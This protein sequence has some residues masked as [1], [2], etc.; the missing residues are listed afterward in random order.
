MAGP[1][2]NMANIWKKKPFK[3][4]PPSPPANLIDCSNLTIDFAA[5]KF[6]N[7]GLDPTDEFNTRIHIITASRYVNIPVDFLNR[8]FR[9]MGNILSFILDQPEKYKRKLF[10]ETDSIS[11]SSMVYQ[12]ENTLVIESKIQDGCRVL[13]NRTDL[14]LLQD[15]ESTIS[16]IIDRKSIIIKPIVIHQID[17]IA[18][19]LKTNSMLKHSTLEIMRNRVRNVNNDFISI[20][21]IGENDYIF[22]SQLKLY[23]TD[24]IVQK[25]MEKLEKDEGYNGQCSLVYSPPSFNS[26]YGQEN[27]PLISPLS[28]PTQESHVENMEYSLPTQESPVENMQYSLPTQESPVENMQYSLPTQESPVENMQYSLPTQE[29]FTENDGPFGPQYIYN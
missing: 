25:W 19:F 5:R 21:V 1:V 8:I 14:L 20:H 4:T 13:L 23:A 27:L 12:S 6:L 24:C 10:L 18:S 28:P 3:Y 11:L 22:T 29:S 9:L 17:L 16:E 15:L 26:L 2:A 7:I